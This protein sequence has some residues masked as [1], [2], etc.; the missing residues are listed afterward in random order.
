[1]TDLGLLMVFL[2]MEI[3]R[4]RVLQNLDLSQ[5]QYIDSILHR[6]E[7]SMAATVSTLSDPHVRLTA[8]PAD[9]VADCHKF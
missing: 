3:R 6:F 1:M 9:H 5:Q 2:G 4:N 8:S 7:M